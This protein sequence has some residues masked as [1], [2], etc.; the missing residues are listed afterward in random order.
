MQN[1][2]LTY[3]ED[4]SGYS[5]FVEWLGNLA[6]RKGVSIIR[7]RIDRL[8]FGLFGD[9]KYLSDGVSELRIQYGPGYR[10]YYTQSE[11][12]IVVLLCAGDKSTQRKDIK[13][14]VSYAKMLKED[15][16]A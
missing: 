5:P 9:S 10:I 3:F 7:T 4:D 2:V 12:R 14:A 6:D 13:T 8:R 15:C 11:G 1:Y 16:R